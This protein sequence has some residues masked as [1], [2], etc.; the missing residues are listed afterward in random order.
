MELSPQQLESVRTALES[1][2][3]DLMLYTLLR[4]NTSE[5]TVIEL[6]FLINHDHTIK[7]GDHDKDYLRQIFKKVF[8]KQIHKAKIEE[9]KAMMREDVALL[10]K[11]TG[12]KK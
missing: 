12:V 2:D 9:T 5:F 7:M 3:F 11:I 1:D 6:Q 8:G 10:H 4:Q